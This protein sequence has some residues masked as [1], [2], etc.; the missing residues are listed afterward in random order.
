M[1]QKPEAKEITEQMQE[2]AEAEIREK[3]RPVD[4]ADFSRQVL[5]DWWEEGFS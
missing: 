3:Q 5:E 1:L 4:Y 2:A